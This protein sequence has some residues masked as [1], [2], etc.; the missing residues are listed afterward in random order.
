M[1]FAAPSTVHTSTTLPKN[2]GGRVW[3][4]QILLRARGDGVPSETQRRARAVCPCGRH[5]HDYRY[6]DAEAH[7][8]ALSPSCRN[9]R[10]ESPAATMSRQ[11]RF[12]S[13]KCAR[14]SRTADG[15]SAGR[16]SD[17]YVRV[18]CAGAVGSTTTSWNN[19][20]PEVRRARAWCVHA[21]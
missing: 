20:N 9:V 8:D 14:L 21:V 19:V 11:L 13:I 2:A 16:T 7:V 17:P 12:S 5:G 1:V 4:T 6:H 15:R 10:T 18:E 3:G